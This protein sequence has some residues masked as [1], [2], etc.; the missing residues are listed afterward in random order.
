M[1]DIFL[2]RTTHR[3]QP[4]V[5][6]RTFWMKYF[7]FTVIRQGQIIYISGRMSHIWY[8]RVWSPYNT[9]FSRTDD[10]HL[11]HSPNPD[12]R[13]AY[14]RQSPFFRINTASFYLAYYLR[15]K[16]QSVYCH[17]HS[18]ERRV[19]LNNEILSLLSTLNAKTSPNYVKIKMDIHISKKKFMIFN[20]YQKYKNLCE[21]TLCMWSVDRALKRSLKSPLLSP[22]KHP[23]RPGIDG[24]V[25]VEV[26]SID[27][28]KNAGLRAASWISGRMK[29]F[30]VEGSSVSL[31]VV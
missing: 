27:T 12:H 4:S 8:E 13:V 26:A 23:L 22:L 24:S 17:A 21:A 28:A 2:Y 14:T 18:E 3:N 6:F 25:L 20:L 15:F 19:S 1:N 16:I 9:Q 7:L 11:P 30:G 10:T 31:T 29:S 5:S